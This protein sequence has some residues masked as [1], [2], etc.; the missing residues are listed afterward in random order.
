MIQVPEII[1]YSTIW[2]GDCNCVRRLFDVQFIRCRWINID[3]D[4]NGEQIVLKLNCG[5]R[6]IP[7]NIF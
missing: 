6:S 3:E 4:R 1:V 5:M 2:C 7:T